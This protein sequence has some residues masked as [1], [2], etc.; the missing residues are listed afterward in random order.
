MTIRRFA[1]P[2]SW[3]ALRLIAILRLAA[4]APIILG[5]GYILMVMPSAPAIAVI[6]ATVESVTFR[7]AIPEMAQIRLTGFAISYEAPN[8]GVNLG[9]RDAVIASPTVKKPLCLDG[10][11]VP[12]PGSKITYKRFGTDPVSVVIERT[13]GKP[14]ASF[15]TAGRE[16]VVNLR[17]ASWIRLEAKS[18]DDDDD[19]AKGC[20][21]KSMQ[22]LPIYGVAEVGSEI[23]PT[24]PGQ[25]PSSGVLI[26][27]T[28]DIFAR[29]L[30]FGPWKEDAPRIYPA[31]VTSITL[32]PGSRITEHAPTNSA[33]QPWTG[34]VRA[35][36]DEALDVKVTTPA[37]K[38]AIIRP[39][40]GMKPEVI[41]IGLF[42]QLANDPV[43]I[44]AQIFAALLFS[45]FQ[46][47]SAG[48]GW[49]AGRKKPHPSQPGHHDH[50]AQTD[51]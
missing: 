21:G 26:E 15:Q 18:D 20:P 8:A 6:Q 14:A 49:L 34:F 23:R 38:L 31:S 29:A 47:M 42:T 9:F 11:L 50:P 45:V 16:A 5:C 1:M 44:A 43:L 4:F 13:D 35:D 10:I 39:G 46:A 2:A 24:G 30:D 51:K 19:S 3:R 41:S 7:A 17:Q 12:E 22:R 28:L 40:V 32:P 36:A 33:L 27:G 37:M 48:L 25:E